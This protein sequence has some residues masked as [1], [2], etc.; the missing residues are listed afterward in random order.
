MFQIEN[1]SQ[2]YTGE[3]L[4]VQITTIP[5]D[6]KYTVSYTSEPIAIGEHNG[7]VTVNAGGYVGSATFVLTLLDPK[8]MPVQDLAV[9]AGDGS[10]TVRWTA[11]T[12]TAQGPIAN[13]TIAPIPADAPSIT[14]PNDS[15]RSATISGLQN[16]K[17]YRFSVIANN[18]YGASLA[19]L[20]EEVVPK[21]APSAPRS[22]FA[23]TNP[24]GSVTVEWDPPVSDGGYPV[25]SYVVRPSS[26][27]RPVTVQGT[28]YTFT[29][30]LRGG[31]SYVF[32][33]QATNTFGTGPASIASNTAIPLT[34]PEPPTVSAIRG[35][36]KATVSWTIPNSGGR[37]ITS[38]VI[39]TSPATL[40]Y[41]TP[42]G[43]TTQ[44]EIYDLDDS[45]AYSFAVY[46]RNDVGN[47]ESG[48]TPFLV[49]KSVAPKRGN[50]PS[51]F[52]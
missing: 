19:A 27:I 47:G 2:Y 6:L 30:G 21:G 10:A 3:R 45:V 11:P 41:T 29:T 42:D 32:E 4:D 8:P 1:T 23:T 50:R 40:A 7:T 34:P 49:G 18:Y 25:T 9:V 39:Q 46:G 35:Y 33:V 14:T 28:S 20:T 24:S 31:Y 48:I 12:N 36:K 37:P 43:A 13:Y 44:Y 22:V 26:S 51:W 38:F 52:A 5:P 16:G 15:A 17:T